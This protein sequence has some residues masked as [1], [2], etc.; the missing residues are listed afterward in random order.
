M[1]SFD[2]P[3]N[4]GKIRSTGEKF[5]SLK[6]GIFELELDSFQRILIIFCGT[7]LPQNFG[8]ILTEVNFKLCY[9]DLT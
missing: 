4:P 1:V 8:E 5:K 2:G 6:L 9:P 3:L 7:G